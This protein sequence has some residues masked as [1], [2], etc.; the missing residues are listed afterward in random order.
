VA[1]ADEFRRWAIRRTIS[2]GS[3][4]LRWLAADSPGQV[5][6][7]MPE[8]TLMDEGHVKLTATVR[9]K[10]YTPAADAHVAAH[11][12]GPDGARRGG[13]DAGAEYAGDV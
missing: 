8:Q 4:L 2:S 12:I 10:E 5:V 3:S 13:H 11:V 7:T 6:A 9:D 1:L